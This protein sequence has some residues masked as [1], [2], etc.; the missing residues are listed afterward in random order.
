LRAYVADCVEKTS[1]PLGTDVDA[2]LARISAFFDELDAQPIPGD[3]ER[4]LTEAYAVIGVWLPLYVK[5]Y[6]PILTDALNAA[7][8]GDGAQLLQLADYYTSR[9]A[10]GFTDNSNEVIYAVSCL[11]HPDHASVST[12]ERS[13][14]RLERASP[15]FGRVFAWGALACSM[16]P[17]QAT[18]PARRSTRRRR[19]DPRHR[20]DPRP[21][22]AVPVGRRAG[23]PAGVGG[24]AE[25]RRRRAH[26]VPDGQRVHR[27]DR[28]VLPHRRHGAARRQGVLRERHA[29]WSAVAEWR[30]AAGRA[31]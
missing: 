18:E 4:Q 27:R 12:V 23:R 31:S 24:A 28:R 19:P 9:G 5:S 6:W 1:C 15:V 22:D 2:G 8:D 30:E 25:P 13:I 3:G 16:W 7:F 20:Y 21:G 14:P 17:V 10:E 11:D 26:G 29:G